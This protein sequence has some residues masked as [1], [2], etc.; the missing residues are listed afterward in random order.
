MDTPNQDPPYQAL[1]I[2]DLAENYS[3]E[4]FRFAIKQCRDVIAKLIAVDDR[5]NQQR[6]RYRI[7]RYVDLQLSRSVKW[8]ER[9]A[10]LMATV[11]RSLIELRFWANY[12]SESE[13][14]ATRFLEEANIDLKELRDRLQKTRPA[15]AEPLPEPPETTEKKRVS[16]GP[17]GD[18]QEE[19]TWKMCSKLIHPSSWGINHFEETVLD[20]N[21]RQFLAI[22]VLQY[23]WIIVSRFHNIEWTT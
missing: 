4:H 5:S 17:S 21:T 7:L 2:S 16:V 18:P 12:V 8:V 15:D 11:M 6:A 3:A 13:E 22:Q 14:N 10:D 19:L 1:A 9:E 23:G 20:P